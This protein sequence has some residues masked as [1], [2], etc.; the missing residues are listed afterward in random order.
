MKCKFCKTVLK[1]ED[2]FGYHNI[3]FCKLTCMILDLELRVSRLE[4]KEKEK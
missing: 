2:K 4:N 1:G 3:G